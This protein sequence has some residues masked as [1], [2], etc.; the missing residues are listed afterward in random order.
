MHGKTRAL[1]FLGFDP[2]SVE[3]GEKCDFCLEARF[4]LEAVLLTCKSQE[5]PLLHFVT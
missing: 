5:R 2:L 4:F 1:S 3:S